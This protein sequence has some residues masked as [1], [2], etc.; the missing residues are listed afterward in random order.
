[1]LYDSIISSIISSNVLYH[2][3]RGISSLA[4]WMVWSSERWRG[5]QVVQPSTSSEKKA[6]S[7]IFGG[8]QLY[9]FHGDF[10]RAC[11]VFSKSPHG[12]LGVNRKKPRF[13][14]KWCTVNFPKKNEGKN[15]ACAVKNDWNC[16]SRDGNDGN[17]R[18][19]ATNQQLF[20]SHGIQAF[21]WAVSINTGQG[22]SGV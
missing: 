8:H 18:M 17:K 6:A 1:M 16:F 2:T 3:D 19:E 14:P 12:S 7:H 20:S 4:V 21:Y 11:R 13:A 5:G 22:V 10:M 15:Q 9:G